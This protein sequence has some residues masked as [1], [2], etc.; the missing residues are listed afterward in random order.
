MTTRAAISS[1]TVDSPS[2]RRVHATTPI[3]PGRSDPSPPVSADMQRDSVDLT[4]DLTV[5]QLHQAFARCLATGS[6][7]LLDAGASSP[8]SAS[9]GEVTH[10]G[11]SQELA[12]TRLAAAKQ[13]VD[14]IQAALSRMADGT[15]GRCQQCGRRITADRLRASPTARWCAACQG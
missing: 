2:T 10:H 8:S 9:V 15:Y 13:A 7:E 11:P 3:R 4:W 1:P 6:T 14:D 12:R 5:H